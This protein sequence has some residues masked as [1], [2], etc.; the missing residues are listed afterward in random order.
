MNVALVLAL[1]ADVRTVLAAHVKDGEAGL[2]PDLVQQV[3]EAVVWLL[4]TQYSA[5]EVDLLAARA[6]VDRAAGEALRSAA[7]AVLTPREY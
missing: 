6:L 1:A 5:A 2:S 4:R 7:F 3:D